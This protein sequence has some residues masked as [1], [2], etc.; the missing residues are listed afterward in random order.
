MW[1]GQ[2][3]GRSGSIDWFHWHIMNVVAWTPENQYHMIIQQINFY[4]I[5]RVLYEHI[6]QTAM[7]EK[8]IKK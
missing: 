2:H 8:V 5:L 1:S 3:L 7:S 4:D 6:I